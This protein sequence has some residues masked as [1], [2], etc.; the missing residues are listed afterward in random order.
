MSKLYKN[1]PIFQQNKQ[2]FN[3]ITNK[4]FSKTCVT[5][6]LFLLALT[7][8]APTT[9]FADHEVDC[10]P[11]GTGSGDDCNLSFTA[12]Q[13]GSNPPTQN[14]IFTDDGDKCSWSTTRL[15]KYYSTH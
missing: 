14:F 3:W 12:V 1:I 15:R 7:V 10:E 5:T 8:F 9:V 13:G 6:I 4:F 2:L 11:D